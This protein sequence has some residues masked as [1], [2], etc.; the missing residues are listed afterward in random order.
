MTKDKLAISVYVLL[1]SMLTLYFFFDTK[2]Y[3]LINTTSYFFP[4]AFVGIMVSLGILYM[5]GL[6]PIKENRVRNLSIIYSLILLVLFTVYQLVK[7]DY[8]YDEAVAYIEENYEYTV[9][10]SEHRKTQFVE[11]GKDIY[12]F[13]VSDGDKDLEIVFDPYT[14]EILILEE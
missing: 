8:S 9:H 1:A 4:Y 6:P 10:Y 2:E 14:S 3:V 5:S 13:T 7:P 12:R 11:D